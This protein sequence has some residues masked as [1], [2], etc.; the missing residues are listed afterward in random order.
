MKCILRVAILA[1]PT[2]IVLILLELAVR[3]FSPVGESVLQLDHKYLFENKPGSRKVFR[4]AWADGG[5]W[6]D[7]RINS[8]GYRGTRASFSGSATKVLV[9]GDSFIAGEYSDDAD[10]FVSRLEDYLNRAS[11]G[12]RLPAQVINAGVTG[13]GPDQI[14]LR[15]EDELPVLR[16]DLV[17]V[18]IFAGNDFGDLLR[19]KIFR[20]GRDGRIVLNRYALAP[21]VIRDFDENSER[22]RFHL[23]RLAALA[24]LQVRAAWK[25][26]VAAD[27]GRT[28]YV[29]QMILDRY[30]EYTE[31]VVRGDNMVRNLLGD[32]YDIDLSIAPGTASA[33]YKIQ[34][35]TGVIKRI[36]DTAGE[37]RSRLLL[38]IVPSIVDACRHYEIAVDPRRHAGYSRE[39]LTEILQRLAEDANVPVV[40]LFD[41]FQV[42]RCSDVFYVSPDDGHWNSRGQ[43]RAAQVASQYILGRGLLPTP[44]TA[45]GKPAGRP[46]GSSGRLHRR[47]T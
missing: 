21:S 2:L 20:V 44:T 28:G 16:P 1:A 11:A 6:I 25:S 47:A 26:H 9:Y 38:L 18:T 23:R 39:R 12:G 36:R 24:F 14:A 27:D 43:D 42:D 31:Y 13:Y 41:Q 19:N 17:V 33:R 34:M 10:T 3:H 37:N 5:R 15:M 8:R 7:V 30:S 45:H 32:D 40:N 4:H 35:M 46:R 29:E 22:S